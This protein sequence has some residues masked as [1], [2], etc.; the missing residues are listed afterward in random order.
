MCRAPGREVRGLQEILLAGPSIRTGPI[1]PRLKAG[2]TL[3]ELLVVI[4][5]IE[6]QMTGGPPNGLFY[7][8]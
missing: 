4:A 5:I 8:A 1:S 3:I 7:Y 2:F 6:A